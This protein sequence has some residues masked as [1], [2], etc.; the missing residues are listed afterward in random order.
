[1]SKIR[2]LSAD[3]VGKIAAGEVVERPASVVKELVENSFDAGADSVTIDIENAGKTLIRIA[4]NGIGMEAEDLKLAP[5]AHTTSKIKDIDDLERLDTFGF[6]GEALASISAVSEVEI[7]SSTGLSDS[8]TFLKVE[9][10]NMQKIR[11]A[12]RVRGTTIE[13]KNL[14]FNV[15]ARKKFLKKESTELAAIIDVAGRFILSHP[16][17]EIKMTSGGKIIFSAG[18]NMSPVERMR[19]VLGSDIADHMIKLDH[20]E[21]KYRLHGYISTPAVTRKNRLSQVFFVNRRFVRSRALNNALDEAYKS[22]LERGRY[23][24]A[25]LFIEIPADSVDV[26]IHP[27]KLLVKF[28]DE[29]LLEKI[30]VAS[31]RAKFEELK[32]LPRRGTFGVPGKTNEHVREEKQPALTDL[33]E[34]QKEFEYNLKPA[35]GYSLNERS[36]YTAAAAP[37]SAAENI[38]LK[39]GKIF[40]IGGCYII[41]IKDDSLTI[42][43]QHAAHER[44]YYEYF[45]KMISEHAED[46]QN[47]L[48]PVRIDLTPKEAVLMEKLKDNFKILNFDIEPFGDNSYIVQ[49]IPAILKDRNIK[50]IVHDVL[51][52]ASG[53]LAAKSDLNDEMVKYM[54]CR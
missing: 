49:A 25:V 9:G 53:A 5:L 37:A 2:M 51:A 54:S 45:K 18:K 30:T 15:P 10:G 44:V 38:F 14:F 21:G 32:T 50:E 11:P 19:V 13:V 27:T 16:A 41:Q 40:Q 46:M 4:D 31:V 43:D 26:N 20:S 23:P 24:A 33:S 7:T 29:P 52:D 28:E 47:L 1:M 8:G 17:S 3:V 36:F 34:I 48:F 6:R 22:M 39:Y 42:I 12:A 35:K